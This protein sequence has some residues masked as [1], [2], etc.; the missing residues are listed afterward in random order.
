MSRRIHGGAWLVVALVLLVSACTR[1]NQDAPT[2]SEATQAI[3]SYLAWLGKPFVVIRMR[4]VW[5]A[6]PL[7]STLLQRGILIQTRRGTPC[8]SSSMYA[9]T[10]KGRF[11]AQ[12][13][14]WKALSRQGESIVAYAVPVGSFG[15]L[16]VLRIWRGIRTLP[17]SLSY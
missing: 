15:R 4:D 14:H 3:A 16:H 10:R 13:D 6:P 5:K 7:N 1:A 2:T 12:Q 17:H 9:L 8:V 11:F